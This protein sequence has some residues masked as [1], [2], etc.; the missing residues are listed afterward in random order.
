MRAGGDFR[1]RFGAGDGF[2]RAVGRVVGT[3][4]GLGLFPVAPATVASLAAAAVYGLLPVGGDSA[5]FWGLVGGAL[6]IGP[7]VCGTLVSAED[8]DP[9]RAVWDEVA[10]MWLTCLF[11][12][13]TLVWVA[14]ALV[15]FRAL[16]VLKPWPIRRFEGLP[17]GWGIMADD[18]AAGVVGAAAL[19]A[20]Y[21]LG[22]G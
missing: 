15:V 12:P 6:V 16:D 7:W 11:L 9:K 10:G 2:V 18:V 21:R 17:G 5:A 1:R 4:L 8:P 20:V 13:K 19:N 22:A 3:G 14:A